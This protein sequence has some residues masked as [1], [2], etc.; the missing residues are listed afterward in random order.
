MAVSLGHLKLR[1]GNVVILHGEVK[2]LKVAIKKTR[3]HP[4]IALVT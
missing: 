3:K 2:G 4:S 1:G